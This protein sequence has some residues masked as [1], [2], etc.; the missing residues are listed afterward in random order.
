MVS[1][2]VGLLLLIS[3]EI[4]LVSCD[5][6]KHRDV[7]TF[8]LDGV[9]PLTPQGLE[10]GPFDSNEGPAQAAQVPAWYVHEPSK[11]CTNCHDT[12]R[13]SR[14]AGKA[15]LIAPVPGLCYD[16]HDDRTV[17]A[18]FVHGPVAVGQCLFCHNPHKSRAGHLL[19]AAEPNLCY[20]C[21][22]ADA[23]AAI[24]AH[25]TGQPSACTDCHDPHVS[26]ERPL[27][28]EGVRKVNGD[29]NVSAALPDYLRAARQQEEKA[30]AGQ[31]KTAHATAFESD[32]L[33]QVLWTVSKL[34]EQ[35]ELRKARAYLE[36]FKDNKAFTDQ[37]RERI[38]QVLN[39]MDRAAGIPAPDG[40][41]P[42]RQGPV[43]EQ[44]PPA[45]PE[46]DDP[47]LRKKMQEN[48]DLFYLSMD[49]YRE[50]K[51]VRAREGFVRV[52]KSGYIPAPMG[53]TIRGY[54]L[55]IDKRLAKGRTPPD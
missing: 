21:H 12:R 6:V 38:A 43:K 39:L 18:K 37:E 33:Y 44:K 20:L 46:K 48:A 45:E 41:K 49:L 9:E 25:S 40:Q 52:L 53:K 51:L 55:D 1:T 50:G 35:G 13:Q 16:C 29:P 8:L 36:E 14:S 23:I 10:N 54:L 32:S 7:L 30:S 5:Q 27:L 15:Y 17:S 24:P 11:D 4:L 47:Q 42:N 3:L 31:S 34:V 22:D 26:L 2:S 28:K 19:K